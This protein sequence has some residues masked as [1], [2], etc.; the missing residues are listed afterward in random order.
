M[1]QWAQHEIRGHAGLE[2]IKRM[3][4]ILG[5]FASGL[6]KLKGRADQSPSVRAVQSTAH[7]DEN[8]L[9]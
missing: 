9:V 2:K 5:N 1:S 7:C 4:R 6:S 3:S 8:D